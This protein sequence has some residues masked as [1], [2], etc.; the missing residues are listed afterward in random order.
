MWVDCKKKKREREGGEKKNYWIFIEEY[1]KKK[2][3]QNR[4]YADL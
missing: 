1:T 3:K 2:D 4:L